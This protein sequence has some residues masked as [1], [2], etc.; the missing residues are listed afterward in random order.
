[1]GAPPGRSP[2]GR[3]PTGWE[4]HREEPHQGGA[5]QGG[6]PL[7]RRTGTQQAFLPPTPQPLGWV[8]TLRL[9][10]GPGHLS[11]TGF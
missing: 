5:P 10:P 8:D 11:C 7:G 4:P 2:T 9:Q 6:T 1:M 3:S